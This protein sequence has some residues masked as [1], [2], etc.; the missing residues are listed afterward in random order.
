MFVS[1]ADLLQLWLH[2]MGRA[3][4]LAGSLPALGGRV[5]LLML[6]LCLQLISFSSGY[7]AWVVLGLS[8]LLSSC[9]GWACDSSD[10]VFVSSADQLQLWL[11]G[12]GRAWSLAGSL[13]ALGGRVS[14]LMLCL[15]LQLISFSSGYMAWTVLGVSLALFLPWVG[16]CLF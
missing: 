15:C 16:V 13:P 5:T 14:L 11:H 10:V 3:W 1:S 9:P 8:L 2:G 6:C 4:S 7:M 12:M